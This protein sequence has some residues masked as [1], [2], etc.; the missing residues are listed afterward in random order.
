MSIS[1]YL[2]GTEVFRYRLLPQRVCDVGRAVVML[3]GVSNLPEG[4][5]HHHISEV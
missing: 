2:L 3:Q 5:I 4:S 1:E